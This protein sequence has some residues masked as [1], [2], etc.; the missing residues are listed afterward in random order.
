MYHDFR[1]RLW[2]GV[3]RW[4]S[5]LARLGISPTRRAIASIDQAPR[6]RQQS[7]AL[8]LVAVASYGEYQSHAASTR[9]A[10]A[11]RAALESA[12]QTGARPFHLPGYCYECAGPTRLLVDDLYASEV[13]GRL[14]PNW[15]ERLVCEHCGLN[16]RLRAALHIF[17]QCCKPR[18][19]DAIYVTE[20]TTPF[21]RQLSAKYPGV[22]GS[23]Y[24]GE[25]LP[26]GSTDERQ[27][28]NESLTR[29]T[30][31]DGQFAHILSF[32]VFEHIPDYTKALAECWRCLQPGGTLLVSVP[33][34]LTAETTLARAVVTADGAIQHRFPPEYHGD[35]LS[36]AGCL[37][38]YHFGW[39]LIAQFK[40]AG[41]SSATGLLYWSEEFGYLGGEQLMLLA[42][43]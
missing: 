42:R 25:R 39:D 21:F 37:C 1:H 17:D 3:R 38:F 13:D 26:F 14:I 24:L 30:F 35:P 27:V 5:P 33:F 11:A 4:R 43:K 10:A 16:N 34:I 15:R 9:D 22:V 7:A 41:F 19:G 12:L 20:Q 36:D 23:E 28:R 31:S 29:L 18:V 40:A 32:D 6:A 2:R 8:P